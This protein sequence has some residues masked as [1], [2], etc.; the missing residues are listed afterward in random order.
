MFPTL[1]CII[2]LVVVLVESVA[3]VAFNAV[4]IVAFMKSR[5]PLR[6]RS[7]YLVINLAV[8]DMLVGGVSGIMSFVITGVHCKC[9]RYNVTVFGILDNIIFG[10]ELLFP[11][12]S[13]TNLAAIS[14]ERA[15]ATFRL[16]RHR[17]IKKW[18]FGVAITVTWISAGL[19]STTL[20]LIR[21][22]DGQASS[23]FF[24]WGSF[25][26]I[27]LFVICVSYASIVFKISCGA[28]PQ[29][30]GAAS[31][32][33]KLTKTLFMV[34]LLSLLM[35]LPFVIAH[36]LSFT[37]DVFASLST[38]IRDRLDTVLIVLY[39]ANSLV[40]P[41]LYTFRMPEFKRALLSV[42]CPRPQQR[43]FQ[44][45][46]LNRLPVTQSASVKI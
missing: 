22:F 37:M 31:T 5:S 4:T 2:W 40:N 14:M 7:M 26:S 28:R 8:S 45:L 19:L 1:E 17:V 23:Y 41:I 44:G 16:F 39:L 38:I 25:N 3:I 21:N 29:H 42:F 13:L 20:V 9:W 15:H 35:W 24:V 43:Q 18:V 30:H 34:T 33:R 27:C 12:A 11:L 10:I 46:S 36:F 6:K 32:E